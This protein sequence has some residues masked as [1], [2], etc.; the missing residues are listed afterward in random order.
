V[1]FTFNVGESGARN[2][3][4]EGEGRVRGRMFSALSE[5]SPR[6]FCD[7]RASVAAS[8]ENSCA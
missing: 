7:A 8:I 3:L 4:P 2:P 6:L 5:T 1:T